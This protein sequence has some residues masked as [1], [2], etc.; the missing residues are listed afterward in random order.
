MAMTAQLGLTVWRND[1]VC[2]VALRVRG[3]DLTD[4]ALAMQV[5]DHGDAA[6]PALI[7]L[8][9]VTNGNAEGLRVAGVRIEG[10]VPVSDLRIRINKSTRQALPYMGEAG[11]AAQLEYALLI[12]GR[13]R[14]VGAF[15]VPAHSYGSDSAPAARPAA[16]GVRTDIG[17]P[18]TGA[19]LTIAGDDVVELVVDGADLIGAAASVAKGEADRAAAAVVDARAWAEGD[20]L[21]A[22]RSARSWS[23]EAESSASAASVAAG[24]AG[25]FV[26]GVMYATTAA[27]LAA[28]AADGFFSV[29][30][31]NAA[32]YARLYQKVNGQAVEQTYLAGGLGLS[33]L[34]QRADTGRTFD[35]T[36]YGAKGNGVADDTTAIRLAMRMCALSGGGTVFFPRTSNFY[37]LAGAERIMGTMGGKPGDPP[38]PR[39]ILSMPPGVSYASDGA[40]I[41]MSGGRV[42]AGSMFY[43]DFYDVPTTSLDNISFTGLFLNGNMENQV[44]PIYP[45]NTPDGKVWQ[46]GHAVAIFAGKKIRFTGCKFAGFFGNGVHVTG[47]ENPGANFSIRLPCKVPSD[48]KVIDCEFENLFGI[49]VC[50]GNSRDVEIAH[51]YF[52]GDGY[53]VGAITPEVLEDTGVILNWDIH[54]NLFDFRDGKLPVESVPRYASNSP[55]AQAARRHTR[56]ALCAILAYNGYTGDEFNEHLGGLKFTDNVVWQGCVQAFNF[57]DVEVSRNRIRNFYEDVSEL[58]LQSNDAIAAGGSGVTRGLRN[59]RIHDNDIRQDFGTGIAL[60]LVEDIS[61]RNNRIQGPPRVGARIERCSGIIAGNRWMDIGTPVSNEA[62]AANPALSAGIVFYGSGLRPLAVVGDEFLETRTGAARAMRHGVVFNIDAAIQTRMEHCTGTG[63]LGNVCQDN[64]NNQSVSQS[65]NMKDGERVYSTNRDLVAR[66]ISTPGTV[67]AGGGVIGESLTVRHA[68]RAQESFIVNDKLRFQINAGANGEVVFQLFNEAG[69]VV[70]NAFAATQ[71]GQVVFA[72]TFDRPLRLGGN[73]R[74]WAFGDQLYCKDSNPANATDGSLLVQQVAAPNS[75]TAAGAPGQRA[76]DND[77]S[78]TCT[79]PNT[80]RR[81]VHADW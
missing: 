79:A 16:W 25:G 32:I 76:Y 71:D 11:D 58:A 56:R 13:T 73:L 23:R 44:Q 50:G 51:C 48:I 54:H 81:G 33:L 24:V 74:L 26:G 52:H 20:A 17:M 8:V 46:H 6:G 69:E 28:T 65:G 72:A 37:L 47:H 19:T 35:V 75:P 77:F 62:F 61:I 67:T 1:D 30:G 78:Y 31:E 3:A 42:N 2:E 57:S 36:D 43:H 49:G 55:Q 68:T 66:S 29:R 39:G 60:T 4:S 10:G 41:K 80:W 34:G 59:V 7:D 5:R 21:P 14:L 9:K 70:S 64:G 27:G 18:A 45:A 38:F 63:I 22:G 40:E 53:W 15:F 12:A